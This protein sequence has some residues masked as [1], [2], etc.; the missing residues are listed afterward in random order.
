MS[1]DTFSFLTT[2]ALQTLIFNGGAEENK[3]NYG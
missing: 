1:I 2:V 3:H